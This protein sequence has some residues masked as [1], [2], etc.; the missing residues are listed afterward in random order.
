MQGS[1]KYAYKIGNCVV[2]NFLLFYDLHRNC[3]YEC[4]G[5]SM[6]N[7]QGVSQTPRNTRHEAKAF[8]VETRNTKYQ[9][10]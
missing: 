2:I 8:R 5:A 4:D 7:E 6:T 1:I 3:D 9:C 10:M